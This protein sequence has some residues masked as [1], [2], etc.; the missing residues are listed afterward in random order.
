M[1][2]FQELRFRHLGADAHRLEV[3][4]IRSSKKSV[5][6]LAMGEMEQALLELVSSPSLYSW[7][8]IGQSSRRVYIRKL[9]AKE[10]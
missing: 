4:E 5:W 10:R 7:A 6:M 8:R 1:P 2:R 9:L 3:L